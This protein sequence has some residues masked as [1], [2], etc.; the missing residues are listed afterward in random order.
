VENQVDTRFRI[1]SISKMFTA[2]AILQLVEQDEISLD[3]SVVECLDLRSTA[4]PHEATIYHMLTMTSGIADWFDESGDWEETW[5][6][7]CRRH[8]IYLFRR[9]ED[10]LPLFANE[11]PVSHVG[12]RHQYNGAGYILLGLVIEKV[13]CV[14]YF[15]FI[16][17]HVFAPAQMRDSNFLALDEVHDQVAEGYMPVAGPDETVTAWRRNIYSTT[18]EAAADG[19]ATS[20]IDDL[21]RFCQALRAGRLLS[22]AMTRAMLRPQVAAREQPFRG[23]TWEYGYGVMFIR[24]DARQIV[25][26]GHTGEEDGVSCRLYSYPQRDLDVIIL[27]NQSWCAGSLAWD[28]HDLILE[29]NP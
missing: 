3:T 28:V 12:A 2:V 24:D 14:P 10:Y 20:T 1:A 23:Y 5:A 8:P 13:S 27:G 25:R 6:A 7:L 4:I 17:E 19:G 29:M 26:W 22:P 11:T 18:P 21:G 15:D 16:R 9:N